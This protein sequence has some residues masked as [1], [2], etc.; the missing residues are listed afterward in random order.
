MQHSHTLPNELVELYQLC[1][2]L[3]IFVGE[4]C[5]TYISEPHE[6][7]PAN[8][9]SYEK[10]FLEKLKNEDEN[11]YLWKSNNWYKFAYI[12]NGNFIVIDLNEDRLGWCYLCNA[13][14]YDYDED[15]DMPIVAKS[16]KEFIERTL[17]TKGECFYWE[18]ESF[19]SY[20]NVF[21]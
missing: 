18:D 1:G 12:E 20:G 7:I 14:N 8:E 16:P 4:Q 6:F 5:R 10:E 9:W 19:I 13:G 21:Y 2:G 15:G 3:G 11:Y 17:Q